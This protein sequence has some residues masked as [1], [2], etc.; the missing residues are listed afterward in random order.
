[1]S[2]LIYLHDTSLFSDNLG[3]HIIMKFINSEI[4]ALFPNAE[5]WRSP[6]HCKSNKYIRSKYQASDYAIICGTNILNSNILK[7]RQLILSLSDFIK[8]KKSILLGAGWWKYQNLPDLVSSIFWKKILSNKALHSVR[9]EYTKKMLGST[10]IRFITNTSCP[11]TWNINNFNLKQTDI[12]CSKVVFTLTDYNRDKNRD[13]KFIKIILNIYDELYFWPQGAYDLDYLKQL[14]PDFNHIK[15]LGRSLKSL[16][17]IFCDEKV[18]YVGTR[19]HA[20]IR[21]LNLGKRSFILGVDNRSIEMGKDI[22]MPIVKI[23]TLGELESLIN[24]PYNLRLKIPHEEISN[25][26]QQFL[27]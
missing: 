16:E 3:D 22:G 15:I 25:W 5:I 19:L 8:Y 24:S 14:L 11:T 20:G 13:L 6:T 7:Y 9:D 27:S 1:M 12:S 21:A 2:D 18:D 10:G 23:E 4:E 17:E 26:R